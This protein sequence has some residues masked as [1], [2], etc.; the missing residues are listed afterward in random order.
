MTYSTPPYQYIL[1]CMYLF[2]MYSEIFTIIGCFVEYN[3]WISFIHSWYAWLFYVYRNVFMKYLLLIP[4][5]L[6]RNCFD[7]DANCRYLL[8]KKH[9]REPDNVK[10][11]ICI[12]FTDE[13]KCL[14]LLSINAIPIYL[15]YSW[16]KILA[17]RLYEPT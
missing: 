4:L 9:I 2:W 7:S 1:L 8:H 12:K 6:S 11:R 13:G 3:I 14:L 15:Q 5:K 17:W 10:R 16:R